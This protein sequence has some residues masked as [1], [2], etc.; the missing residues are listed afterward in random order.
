MSDLSAVTTSCNAMA[1]TLYEQQSM[2]NDVQNQSL[3]QPV[4]LSYEHVQV[5]CI[6]E[7]VFFKQSKALRA[8]TWMSRCSRMPKFLNIVVPPCACAP[9]PE[10]SRHAFCTSVLCHASCKILLTPVRDSRVACNRLPSN[11]RQLQVG[12]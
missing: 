5:A 4:C 3:I 8:R 11:G 7:G 1:S 12:G 2:T 9:P 6:F 10:V